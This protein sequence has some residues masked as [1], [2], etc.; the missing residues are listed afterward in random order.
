[1]KQFHKGYLG[2]LTGLVLKV[3]KSDGDTLTDERRVGINSNGSVIEA[4]P[5]KLAIEFTIIQPNQ[6]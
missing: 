2:L 1:M 6:S 5:T 4:R 3:V